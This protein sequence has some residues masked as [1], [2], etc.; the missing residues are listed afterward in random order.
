MKQSD[1][2]LRLMEERDLALVFGWRNSDRVRLKMFESE[3]IPWENHLKWFSGLQGNVESKAF[4]FECMGD[5]LGV[6]C[7][8]AVAARQKR[9]IWGCYLGDQNIFPGA[10]TIMGILAMV[11]LFEVLGIEELVGEMVSSNRVSERFNARLGFRT[12]S[13]FVKTTST[14]RD[15]P[16]TLLTQT[17]WE[18]IR[19][20]PALIEKY[21][22]DGNA[23]TQRSDNL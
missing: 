20:K 1:F 2:R 7:A 19:N 15:V 14:G 21:F 22:V 3:P 9:W 4:M 8:K 17:R 12:V 18:W 11:E 23:E 10:G 6:V 16:A 5:A 13:H